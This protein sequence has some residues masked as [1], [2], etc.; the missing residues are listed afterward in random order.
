MTRRRALMSLLVFSPL[1]AACAEL[2]QPSRAWPAP[3]GLL[4]QGVDPGR[5]AVAVLAESFRG[6]S[7]GIQNDPA[8]IAR[9]AALLEWL[10][11]EVTGQPRWAPLPGAVRERIGLARDEMRAALGADPLAPAP[12][13]SAALAAA[14][15]SLSAGDRA[16]AAAALPAPLFPR[17]GE[18]ALARLSDPGPLPQAEIATGTLAEQVRLLDDTGGWLTGGS[19]PVPADRGGRGGQSGPY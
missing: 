8:R 15:R 10:A 16:A 4:P 9:A 17:G 12:R 5:A 3:S 2:R 1:V 18:A 11:V 6:A 7:A 14:Y 19:T 13:L